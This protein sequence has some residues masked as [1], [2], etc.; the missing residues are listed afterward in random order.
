MRPLVEVLLSTYDGGRYVREQVESVL[1]QTHDHLS[2]TVR[3][4]GSSDDTLARLAE[5][6]DAR[7]TVRQGGNLGLP[8]A[9]FRLIDES[10]DDADL[11]ALCDQDDV[12]LPHKLQ[13]AVARLDGV[14]GPALYCARVAVVDEDL[15]PLYLHELPCRGP[16]FANAL[17]QNIALGCTVVVNREARDLLRGRWPREC[18]MHDAW[19]Y[20]VVAG[21]GTVVYDHE[22]VVLYRQH[23]RN[24]VGMGRGPV[25][26]LAGRVRRQLSADGP[27]K[28]GRQDVELSRLFASRL[29]CGREQELARLLSAPR[30]WIGAPHRQTAA[31]NLVLRTLHSLGR[32]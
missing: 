9:F 4:D 32:V 20:L 15:R 3:D 28:H 31:S 11:W 6:D 22:P 13:R 7:L 26:R 17:V 23:G 24:S 30:L 14:K 8:W 10:S 29:P 25:S 21:C 16:S 19:A 5:V 1:A 27:G 12:W 18:V 2:L